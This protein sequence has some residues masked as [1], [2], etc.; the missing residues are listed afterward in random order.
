MDRHPLVTAAVTAVLGLTLGH[1]LGYLPV[2]TLALLLA[3]AFIL[4]GAGR[5]GHLCYGLLLAAALYGYANAWD[6]PAEHVAHHTGER[7]QLTATVLEPPRMEGGRGRF[8]ARAEALE[9]DGATRPIIGNLSVIYTPAKGARPLAYGDRFRAWATL[10]PIRSLN[11]PGGFDHAAHM[12]RQGILARA[13][14]A[15]RDTP[16][17]LVPGH[18][19]MT[20]VHR[21][22]AAMETAA[23]AALGPEEAALLMA[24]STGDTDRVSDSLRERFQAAGMTHVL[25]ISGTHMGL[26]AGVVFLLV[27]LAVRGLPHRWLLGLSARVTPHALAAGLALL[28]VSGYALLSGWRVPTVRSLVM[29]WLVMLALLLGRRAHGPTGLAAAALLILA[30]DPAALFSASFQLSFVAVLAILLALER[31]PEPPEGPRPLPWRLRRW[32]LSLLLVTLAAGLATAPLVAWHF[33][34][35]NWPGFVANLLLVPMLGVAVLPLGLAAAVAAPA[36]GHLPLAGVVD[37]LLAA[38]I[39]ATSWFA[40]LPGALQ[41]VAMPPL[42]LVLATYGAAL[43]AILGWRHLAWRPGTMGIC[44][45]GAAWW[46]ALHPAPPTGELRVAFLDVGQGDAAVLTGPAGDTLVIDGGTRFGRFDAG[47]L[48]VAPFLWQ[49]GI[50]RVTLL[51]SHPQIDHAGGLIHLIPR[52]E[53]AAFAGNGARR[54]GARF[55]NDLHRALDAAGAASVTLWRGAGFAPLHGVETAVLSPAVPPRGAAGRAA[56]NDSLVIRVGYGAHHFLFT[57]DIEAPAEAALLASGLPLAATV[58]KVPHHGSATSSGD[59]F[60]AAVR[61]AL[62]V[63]EVGADN[64]YGHPAAAVPDRYARHHIPLR[65]TDRDGTVLFRS[66]GRTLRTATWAALAPAPIPPW[67]PRPRGEEWR[68]LRRLLAPDSLWTPL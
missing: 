14:I 34:Q 40:A 42:A 20:A 16:E 61:P 31:L 62:A 8:T 68:N 15:R 29:V 21:W 46:L 7:V 28:A 10:R 41:H 59:G 24:L 5:A 58:L 1:A 3:L 48:A 44:V 35:V 64:P 45:F 39:A 57:G 52:F 32:A 38:F 37:G 66:D 22:R 47:R 54:A 60:L 65:R 30:A 2:A 4:P 18:G 49:H 13:T 67:H 43:L 23:N 19:F 50:R 27:R 25:S 56:N 36:L 33:G 55:D 12:A 6:L 53:V 9:A 63:I 26:V 17:V 11:N 51:A